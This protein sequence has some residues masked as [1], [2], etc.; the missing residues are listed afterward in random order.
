MKVLNKPFGRRVMLAGSLEMGLLLVPAFSNAAPPSGV[1][2]LDRAA[3]KVARPTGVFLVAITRAGNR[4]IASGEHG[5]IIYSDDNG[6]SWTQASV[7]VD[8]TITCMQFISPQTGWAAG[9]F[10]VIL[11]T[12]DGGASWQLQLQGLQVNQLT[13]A[14]AQAATAANSTVPGAPFA[15]RRANFFVQS[16]PSKPFLSVLA[17]SP[18][19]VIVFGAYRMTVMTTDAGKTWVDWS[20]H[21]YD[22][23]SNNLYAALQLDKTIY[24]V[25]EAGLVFASTDGGNS[26]LPIPTP[27]TATLF[28]VLAAADGSVTVFGVAGTCLRTTDAGKS[29]AQIALPT[30]NNLTSGRVLRSNALLI[31][32]EDGSLFMSKDNGATYK[33][34]SGLPNV[35]IFD[36]EEA[37][38]GNLILVSDTGITSVAPAILNS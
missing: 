35:A 15:M 30:T 33:S 8:V 7:P 13:L 17:L 3:I 34:L 18:Q 32:S 27:A 16:G 11:N 31:A 24:V 9:A 10:G 25:G 5:V 20:L 36:L 14:A 23:L 1:D 37:A 21:I 6:T 29:W 12:T 38:N 26:F 28:G 2:A 4:L 19:Q 22:R